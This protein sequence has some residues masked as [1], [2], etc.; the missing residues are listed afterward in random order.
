[1]RPPAD[2]ADDDRLD[3]AWRR[4]DRRA[5]L[6]AARPYGSGAVDAVRQAVSAAYRRGSAAVAVLASLA[7]AVLVL[8]AGAAVYVLG[9]FIGEITGVSF[10]GVV[11]VLAVVAAGS[12]TARRGRAGLP[13]RPDDPR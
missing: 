13:R 2:F 5:R 7:A 1:M 12:Y 10:G 9:E 11:A 8:G 6:E 3:A 4:A